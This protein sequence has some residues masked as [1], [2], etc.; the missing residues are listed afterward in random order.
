[1]KRIL[2]AAVLT[3][4]AC[5]APTALSAKS[6]VYNSVE[7]RVEVYWAAW[8]CT[9]SKYTCSGYFESLVCKSK[10]LKTGE[11]GSYNYKSSTSG[12]QVTVV[13]CASQA[14]D[15]ANTGNK[16]SKKRC[17]TVTSTTGKFGVKC[18]YSEEEYKELKDEEPAVV[19]YPR[20]GI[21]LRDAAE[22][23]AA[24]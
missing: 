13:H 3:A 9:G 18:G 22:R 14:D 7:G 21:G 8:G 11:S 2:L 16:G 1:M 23:P 4:M 19:R 12:R 10:T 20:R 6:K 15:F 24:R 17:A 5:A